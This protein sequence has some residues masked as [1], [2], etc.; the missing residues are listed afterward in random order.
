[1]WGE[2][3]LMEGAP[4]AESTVEEDVRI[5]E[6]SAIGNV[7]TEIQLLLET[8]PDSQ[9]LQVLSSHIYISE[10]KWGR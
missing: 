1:M 10:Y 4:P 9:L 8:G 7:F 3:T 2:V 6:E 5:P